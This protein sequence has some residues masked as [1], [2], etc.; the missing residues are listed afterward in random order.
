MKYHDFLDSCRRKNYGELSTHRH[1]ILPRSDGGSD[2]PENLIDISVHDHFWAHV[3]YAK[4]FNKCHTAPNF[5]LHHYKTKTS[6]T[7]QEWNEAYRTAIRLMGSSKIGNKNMLGKS[8]SQASNEQNRLKHVGNKHT[9]EIIKTIGEASRAM[10]AKRKS[11]PEYISWSAGRKWYNNGLRS[12]MAFERPDGFTRGRLNGS[13]I[14]KIGHKKRK[15]QNDNNNT[16]NFEDE[17]PR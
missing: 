13:H 10:W 4:E 9:D 6:F 15:I 5:L 1:H 16:P 8:H 14:T 2:E 7:E 11:N 3:W 12:V 17:I